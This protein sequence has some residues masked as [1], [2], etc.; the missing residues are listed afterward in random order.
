[1]PTALSEV[2]LAPHLQSA[3]GLIVYSGIA[4]CDTCTRPGMRDK[5]PIITFSG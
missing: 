2:V 3:F 1:M 4:N 5:V